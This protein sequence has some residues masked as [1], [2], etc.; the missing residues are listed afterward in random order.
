MFVHALH[1]HKSNYNGNWR[2]DFLNEPLQTGLMEQFLHYN[3]KAANKFP[4]LIMFAFP[5]HSHFRLSLLHIHKR[6]TKKNISKHVETIL[7]EEKAKSNT[8]FSWT[9]LL[10]RR[11]VHTFLTEEYNFQLET[12]R[13]TIIIVICRFWIDSL[14]QEKRKNSN[15]HVAKALEI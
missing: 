7:E 6:K 14:S 5:F 11:R 13:K 3:L 2:V 12:S 4:Y 10:P 8:H 9:G 1:T 15:F